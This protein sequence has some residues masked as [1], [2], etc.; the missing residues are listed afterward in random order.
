MLL[1]LKNL[2]F[3]V[4][5][6]GTVAILVPYRIVS[7][8]GLARAD[9]ARLAIA[10]PLAAVGA[11]IYLWCLWDFAVT[12]RGT[13]APIDPPK[14]LVVRGLYRYVRNPMY[15]GVLAIIAAWNLAFRTTVLLAYSLAVVVAFHLFVRLFEEPLLRHRFGATYE[16][17]LR[18]VPRWIPRGRLPS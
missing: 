14:T 13:P 11:A 15:L 6:P 2:A 3:T 9:V 18:T 16:S 1:F 12:G 7:R 17:Y 5:V 10:A 4:L 8:G